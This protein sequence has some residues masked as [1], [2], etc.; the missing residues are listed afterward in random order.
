MVL[1]RNSASLKAAGEKLSKAQ[2]RTGVECLVPE[3]GNNSNTTLKEGVN[4]MVY[5]PLFGD[6]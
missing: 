4:M 2:V 1:P 5:A 6:V 3:V